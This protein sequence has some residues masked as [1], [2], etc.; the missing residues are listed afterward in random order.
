LVAKP[1][2]PKLPRFDRFSD[3]TALETIAATTGVR[4]H[5]LRSADLSDILSGHQYKGNNWCASFYSSIV[6]F[7]D[8]PVRDVRTEY[9]E[10]SH[11]E[12]TA[13]AEAHL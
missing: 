13:H 1:I 12:A 2:G 9:G 5:Q 10:K 6:T 8:S 3:E 11:A 7:H 4:Y